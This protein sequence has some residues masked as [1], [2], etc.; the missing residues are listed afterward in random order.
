MQV[1][2][3]IPGPPRGKARHRTMKSGISFN[4]KENVQYENLVKISYQQQ[5][6]RKMGEVIE[7]D[8]WAYFPIPQSA[9]K[10]KKEQMKIGQIRPTVKPDWDNIGK[11]IC[12]ALNNIA[13][14]DDKI[15]TD[16]AVH[17]RY[18]ENPQVEVTFTEVM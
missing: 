11:I 15:I 8:I 4:P 13:Y 14:S 3:T 9:N 18:S 7:A 6:N 10:K 1:K 12:D 5:V 17:K 2:F 16:A